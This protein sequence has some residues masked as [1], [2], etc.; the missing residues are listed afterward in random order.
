MTAAPAQKV[1]PKTKMPFYATQ[2]ITTYMFVAITEHNES[3]DKDERRADRENIE[4]IVNNNDKARLT[5]LCEEFL[6]SQF[7][8]T[9]TPLFA[10]ILNSIYLETLGG[11]L[12]D[13]L[14]D[15]N[16]DAKAEEEAETEAKYK[17]TKDEL[18]AKMAEVKRLINEK[19]DAYSNIA[20]IAAEMDAL[21]TDKVISRPYNDCSCKSSCACD[22]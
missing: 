19:N 2:N 18:V 21:T 20:K 16:V 7:V 14:A 13:W 9:D 15:E 4:E 17:Q 10:A 3:L 5:E 11:Y 12:M 8:N 1:S 6:S 22:D